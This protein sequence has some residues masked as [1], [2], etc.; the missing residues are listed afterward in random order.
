MLRIIL[1]RLNPIAENIQAEEKAGFRKKRITIEQILN[2]RIMTDK[3]I[4]HGRI[5]YHNF[6]DFKNAFDRVWHE[7]LRKLMRHVS[8]FVSY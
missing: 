5:L 4:E 3:H 8:H 2:C 7:G 1:N 6:D